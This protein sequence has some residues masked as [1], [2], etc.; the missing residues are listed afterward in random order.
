M[1]SKRVIKIGLSTDS[2]DRAI[3]ELQTYRQELRQKCSIFVQ[4]LAEIGIE[5]IDAHKY[6][7]GDSDFNDMR[8]H[9]WLDDRGSNVF[10]KLVLSGKDVAFIEFGA[11][12]HYNGSGSPHPYGPPLGMVI[13]SYGKGHGLDDSWR[14]YDEERGQFRLSYGTEAAMPMYNADREIR[15]KF[16]SIAKEVFS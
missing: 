8:T 3:Q 15:Q 16:L 13:G 6:S 14:Y 5:T 12:V 10:A 9:V 11:G 4:R 7:R 2:I 1:G